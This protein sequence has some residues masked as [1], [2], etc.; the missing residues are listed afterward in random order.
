M[1]GTLEKNIGYCFKDKEILTLALTHASRTAS[2]S[3]SE[4]ATTSNERLEFFGDRIL[5]LV[6]AELL[7]DRFPHEA[8]G[9]LSRRFTA[10]VR[11]E[12]LARVA[13]SLTLGPNL[14]LSRSES[15]TGGRENPSILADACEALIAAIYLDGGMKPVQKFIHTHWEAI[16]R[17]DPTP[18]KDAKT[19][20]QEWSQARELGLPVYDVV[21]MSGPSHAPN[22]IISVAIGDLPRQ[23]ADGPSKRKAEQSAAQVMLDYIHTQNDRNKD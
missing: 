1:S 7:Y 23:S 4:K 15:E 11:M 8:E 10:L 6:I 22:F 18:P 3:S 13:S 14:D 9:L 5:G 2:A 17:E 19:S 21:S 12:T 16:L 20:L